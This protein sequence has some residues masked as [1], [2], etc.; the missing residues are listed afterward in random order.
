MGRLRISFSV[1]GHQKT[2]CGFHGASIDF[3][4]AKGSSG[5]AREEED[6]LIF[7][8]TQEDCGVPG[9]KAV[10]IDIERVLMVERG[11]KVGGRAIKALEGIVEAF[12]VDV[13]D[14]LSGV[15]AHD[16]ERNVRGDS[17]LRKELLEVFDRGFR[18]G[19]RHGG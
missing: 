5:Q 1:E 4:G 9:L 14:G 3:L 18:E 7:V 11:G 16:L 15:M 19:R 13:E 2:S 6:L 10:Q 8:R 17:R 12:M